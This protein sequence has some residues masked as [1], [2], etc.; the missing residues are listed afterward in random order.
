MF[1]IRENTIYSSFLVGKKIR[2]LVMSGSINLGLIHIFEAI[3]V[4]YICTYSLAFLCFL[5]YIEI[6]LKVSHACYFCP[7]VE[8]T[9]KNPTCPIC[10]SMGYLKHT[11]SSL[12]TYLVEEPHPIF[13][14]YDNYSLNIL[15]CKAKWFKTSYDYLD[16]PPQLHSIS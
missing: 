15:F 5:V 8:Y 6:N 16:A 9:P 4:L 10:E 12:L 1:L 13:V 3:Y 2:I 7:Y 11:I 14:I